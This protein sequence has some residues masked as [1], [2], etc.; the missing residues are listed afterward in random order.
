MNDIHGQP[1]D[2]CSRAA[3]IAEAIN[4]RN[5]V[6]QHPDGISLFYFAGHGVQ[7]TPRDTVLLMDDFNDPFSGGPLNNAVNVGNLYN[8]LSVHASRPNIARSQFFFVDACRVMPLQLAQYQAMDAPP[9]WPIELTAAD[10]RAAPL[11]Y[12]AQ[13]GTSAAARPGVSTLF[14]E[15]LIGCLDKNAAILDDSS[16]QAKWTVSSSSLK[17]AL[18]KSLDALNK[19][20][21]GDQVVVVDGMSGDPVLRTL[22]GP[23]LVQQLFTLEP[24]AASGCTTVSLLS[25]PGPGTLI[26]IPPNPSA[27]TVPGGYYT[28]IA[29]VTPPATFMSSQ[30]TVLIDYLTS[31]LR[32]TV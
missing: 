19:L 32:V 15:A 13:S 4:W 28:L 14:G 21:G 6:V 16:G 3:F 8:G 10:Q 29:T 2:R 25:P 20:Y 23:P 5:D 9:I 12:A 22:P 26:P 18:S 24:D 17:A 1:V 31:P 7:R 11:F 27:I 30:R